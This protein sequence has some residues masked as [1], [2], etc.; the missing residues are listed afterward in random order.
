MKFNHSKVQNQNICDRSFETSED[1]NKMN[2]AKF[3]IYK[4]I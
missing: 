4:G 1:N 3:R 2:D